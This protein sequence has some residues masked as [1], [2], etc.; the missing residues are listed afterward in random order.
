MLT[1]AKTRNA[2]IAAHAN[3]ISTGKNIFVS[4]TAAY[5]S[6][7]PSVPTSQYALARDALPYQ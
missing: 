5:T 3:G 7:K 4:S 6:Q 1:H 2:T